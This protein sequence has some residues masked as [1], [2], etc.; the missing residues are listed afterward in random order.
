MSEPEPTDPDLPD[1]SSGRH[2]RGTDDGEATRADGTAGRGAADD[3]TADD[4]AADDNVT[5]DG[6]DGGAREPERIVLYGQDAKLRRKRAAAG[7]VGVV[8]FAAAFGGVAGLIG[9]LGPGLVVAGIV[10]AALGFVV[11]SNARRQ[12]WLEDRTV[13]M[14]SWGS[15]RVDLVTAPRIELLLSD[16]RGSRTVSLLVTSESNK[17]VKVDLAIYAGTGGRELGILAL[18]RLADAL[19]DNIE[20]NGLVFSELLVAQL[21][22]EARGDAAADRPLYR[23]ASLAPQGKLAQRFTME[24]VSRFV[25]SLG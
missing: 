21:R 20:A 23:I 7:L 11:M 4:N 24:A 14:R 15:R 13:V 5:D 2:D 18:R 16:V 8:L 9:G 12:V 17:A 10:A 22:S 25:A 6:A 1:V 19:A 3:V